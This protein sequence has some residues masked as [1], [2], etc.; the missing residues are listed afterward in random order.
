MGDI[1][2]SAPHLPFELLKMVFVH[3]MKNHKALA[4]CMLVCRAWTPC[5]CMLLY[6]HLR[7]GP[8][9]HRHAMCNAARSPSEALHMLLDRPPHV[10]TVKVS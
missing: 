4:S 6:A 2:D 5:A 10:Q 8:F 1:K 7:I 3:L 9:K